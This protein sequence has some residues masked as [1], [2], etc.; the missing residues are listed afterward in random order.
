MHHHTWLDFK[1]FSAGMWTSQDWQVPQN[2]AALLEDCYPLPQGGL[3]AFGKY[4]TLT[5]SGLA[6]D[7]EP[8]AIWVEDHVGGSD[9]FLIV[10]DGSAQKLYRMDESAGATSWSLLKTFT[11]TS[12]EGAQPYMTSYHLAGEDDP[13]IYLTVSIVGADAGLWKVN[14]DT[15]VVSR[16]AIGSPGVTTDLLTGPLCVHQDRLVVCREFSTIWFTNPGVEA[17]AS[18]N[19]IDVAPSNRLN[20]ITFLRSYAPSDLLV[21]TRGAPW[22]F[23]QGDMTDP[24]IRAMGDVR[25]SSIHQWPAEMDEGIGFQAVLD[26]IYTSGDGSR[27]DKL[28]QAISVG[29]LWTSAPQVGGAMAYLD[30]WLFHPSGFC[31][32]S[33]TGAWF[34]TSYLDTA[35]PG[36]AMVV[37]KHRNA[38][39]VIIAKQ[40]GSGDVPVLYT[41]RPLEGSMDRSSTFRYT[42][43]PLHDDTGRQIEICEVHAVLKTYATGASCTVTVNGTSRLATFH[44]TVAG[45]TVATAMFRERG[46]QLDVD[47]QMDSND[48]DV[49]APSIESVRVG[50][51]RGHLLRVG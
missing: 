27:F 45:R 20:T 36:N 7:Q 47:I 13:H 10:R 26:G 17:I 18:T 43:P 22:Q 41:F 5:T 28:S 15:G 11:A 50:V 19:F 40:G 25:H 30:N 48:P 32:D 49:E 37:N 44:D 46:A 51:L 12:S 21:A 6:A 8:L 38:H 4:D 9:Y 42:S 2:G 34:K 39:K 1:D 29:D 24:I 14:N 31:Y 23:I 16:P 33:R 35:T 3:R